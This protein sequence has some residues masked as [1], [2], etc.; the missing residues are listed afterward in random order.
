MQ[1]DLKR[2]MFRGIEIVA[3]LKKNKLKSV[4]IN[5]GFIS[6]YEENSQQ[7]LFSKWLNYFPHCDKH[8]MSFFHKKHYE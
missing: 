8:F 1:I 5:H 6:Y 2:F 7:S 4:S 3:D